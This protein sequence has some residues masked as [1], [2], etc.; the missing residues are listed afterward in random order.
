V[1]VDD[2]FDVSTRKFSK[3]DYAVLATQ[4][5]GDDIAQRGYGIKQDRGMVLVRRPEV[6]DLN[7]H[8]LYNDK[9]TREFLLKKFPGMRID[10]D[11]DHRRRAV[12]W[13]AVIY[14]YWRRGMTASRVDLNLE[15][16]PGTANCIVQQIRRVGR[17]LRPGGKTYS[18]RKR[19]R[20]RKTS[21]I[22]V[23]LSDGASTLH[24]ER[25][26]ATA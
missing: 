1:A 12:V 4:F 26:T 11:S 18:D 25:L 9:G 3:Q 20:P 2:G 7:F 19:G 21:L 13:N 8:F 23:P 5:D 22:P 6:N 17:G 15:L 10:V 24:P 14:Y 16:P